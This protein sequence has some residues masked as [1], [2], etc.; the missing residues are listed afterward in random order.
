M[1]RRENTSGTS[2]S[3][4]LARGN[5]ENAGAVRLGLAGLCLTIRRGA[6]VFRLGLT[7]GETVWLRNWLNTQANERQQIEDEQALQDL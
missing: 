4:D 7:M 5:V 3:R 1:L 2:R 6:V